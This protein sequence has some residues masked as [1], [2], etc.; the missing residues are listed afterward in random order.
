MLSQEPALGVESKRIP[1]SAHHCTMLW[2]LCAARLSK[3][4]EHSH[5]REKAI[6]LLSSW[7]D[8]P[9]LPTPAMRNRFRSGRTLFQDK[10]S[11]LAATRD[12]RPHWYFAGL[13]RPAVL[14]WQGGTR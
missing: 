14:P 1:C 3:T 9:I 7:I 2:L 10:P 13:L 8:I 12:A 11:V 4:Q 5:G 6:Q